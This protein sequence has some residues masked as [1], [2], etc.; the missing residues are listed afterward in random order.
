MNSFYDNISIIDTY[1]FKEK[2]DKASALALDNWINKEQYARYIFQKIDNPGWIKYF[3]DMDVFSKFPEPIE[4]KNNK[5]FYKMPAWYAGDYLNRFANSSPKIVN[6]IA[7][8]MNTENS[9]VIRTMLNSL[10]QIPPEYSVNIIDSIAK[11]FESSFIGNVLILEELGKMIDHLVKGDYITEALAIFNF[12]SQPF[13]IEEKGVKSKFK[14]G[15]KFDIY[16]LDKIFEDHL[17]ALIEVD[18]VRVIEIIESSLK[19][20]L[21]IEY[22]DDKKKSETA[23]WAHRIDPDKEGRY[24]SEI[25]YLLKDYLIY[26]IVNSVQN[27]VED[28]GKILDRYLESKNPVFYRIAVYVLTYHA[29]KFEHLI[30]KAYINYLLNDYKLA[31]TEIVRLINNC[32]EHFPKYIQKIIL[33]D[34][35]SFD[36]EAMKKVEEKVRKYGR[37]IEGKSQIDK[38]MNLIE[39]I[40]LDQ[41]EGIKESLKQGDSDYYSYLVKKHGMPK[42]KVNDGGVQTFIGSVSPI[43]LDELSKKTI[44]G[45]IKY[46][47]NYVPTDTGWMVDPSIEGL[48]RVFQSDVTNRTIAYTEHADLLKDSRLSLDYH[49][50]Y[51]LGVE[52]AIKKESN[53]DYEKVID[54]IHYISLLQQETNE[55]IDTLRYVKI[56]GLSLLERLMYKKEYVF[57]HDT[58]NKIED[59]IDISLEYEIGKPSGENEDNFDPVTRSLNSVRGMA[60][61][62]LV[63][64]GLYE[65]RIAKESNK[66]N[67]SEKMSP[68][69]KR[70]LTRKL[71]KSNDP[72]LGVHS[73]FGQYFP[74][75]NYLD[76]EWVSENINKIFPL[77]NSKFKYWYAAWNSYLSY[78]DVFKETFPKLISQYDRYLDCLYD[79]VLDEKKYP[80]D[81]KI[82][83][84]L[85]KAYLLNL[86]D[87]DSEDNLLIKYYQKSDDKSR[88]HGVFWLSQ[89][90]ES[91]KPSSEDSI[92]IKTW[93]LWKW[94]LEEVSPD[95]GMDDNQEEL[96]SYARLLKSIP[97]GIEFSEVYP[98]LKGT[99]NYIGRDFEAGLILEYLGMNCSDYSELANSILLEM[100]KSQKELYIRDQS[101]DLIRKIL[102]SAVDATKKT[103]KMAIETINILGEREGVYEL[104]ALLDELK[105]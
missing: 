25:K 94:R 26:A 37:E 11:W 69:V 16:W 43:E 4:D 18:P 93:K 23:F 63:A 98:V 44:P 60:M 78:S 46:L 33:G 66:D 96:S 45:V 34:I 100:I 99:L 50:N 79:S 56:R 70:G 42:T 97:E 20:S 92:W 86:I 82:S 90:L 28:I 51:F 101:I 103:K 36:P 12:L 21:V 8:N 47:I 61:H 3:Y 49:S 48:G 2:P 5:G 30:E 73:V 6:D 105:I 81:N 55:K 10:N 87:I 31:R 54:L 77:A 39:R 9:R 67:A 52:T 40:H 83:S 7:L 72:C 1:I 15:T 24:H 22:G 71:N 38:L 104:R 91:Q 17:S 75:I 80:K 58:K 76:D 53:I 41:L 65:N 84:H 74:Q 64:F 19:D 85:L 89:V 62:C 59:V 29:D 35:Y 13:P 95:E 14:A 57:T 32:Y 102:S 88:S 27:H 68:F